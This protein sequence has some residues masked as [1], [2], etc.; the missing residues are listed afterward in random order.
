MAANTDTMVFRIVL[1]YSAVDG[2]QTFGGRYY[3]LLHGR[4]EWGGN[5]TIL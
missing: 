4:N 1:T 3:L 5:V 2:H